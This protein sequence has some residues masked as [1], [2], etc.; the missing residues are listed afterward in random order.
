M[1]SK[2]ADGYSV[3]YSMTWEGDFRITPSNNGGAS[4]VNVTVVQHSN[5]SADLDVQPQGGAVKLIDGNLAPIIFSIASVPMVF[6]QHATANLT[7]DGSLGNAQPKLSYAASPQLGFSYDSAKGFTPIAKQGK[8]KA[9]PRELT[10]GEN[11]TA[12]GTLTDSLNMSY[13]PGLHDRS[14]GE[15]SNGLRGEV[16]ADLAPLTDEYDTESVQSKP[17][18]IG[19]KQYVGDLEGTITAPA[20]VVLKMEDSSGNPF[21]GSADGLRHGGKRID[22]QIFSDGYALVDEQWPVW[23][24]EQSYRPK[25]KVQWVTYRTQFET[26]N[27]VTYPIFQFRYPDNWQVSSQ[28]DADGEQVKL[29]SPSGAT[30]QYIMAP[31]RYGA[32][33]RVLHKIEVTKAADSSFVP[34]GVQAEDYSSLGSFV[35]A[36]IHLVEQLFMDTDTDYTA[37]DIGYYYAVI[38]Q[39][40]LGNRDGVSGAGTPSGLPECSSWYYSS[41]LTFFA[42]PGSGK[43]F[44]PD[45]EQT[46]LDI[47]SSFSNAQ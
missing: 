18:E 10:I 22:N 12:S 26:K 43:A 25:K 11:G 37:K 41:T 21:D 17:I 13:I 8:T 14:V 42:E 15:I 44:T 6:T 3:Q 23:S 47:L 19:G 39:S 16:T 45:E 5:I 38:P 31:R 20:K 34:E 40:K 32:Y 29:T 9:E 46:V 28:V 27:Q 2:E 7:F 30:V 4:R 24:D 33:G 35:V 36:K 1:L